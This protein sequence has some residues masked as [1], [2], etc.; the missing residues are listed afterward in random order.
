[1]R[2]FGPQGFKIQFLVSV[3]IDTEAKRLSP[4][5]GP[6]FFKH[7]E[8]IELKMF[9]IGQRTEAEQE[10]RFKGLEI[11]RGSLLPIVIKLSSRGA[12][13]IIF[14]PLFLGLGFFVVFFCWVLCLV[15]FT[16]R[17]WRRIPTFLQ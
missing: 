16:K 14:F 13:L 17:V 11:E 8:N 9:C 1:M 15:F 10:H 3:C 6:D 4:T 12:I 7:C 2:Y 5:A